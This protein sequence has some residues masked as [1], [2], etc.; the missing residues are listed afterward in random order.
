MTHDTNDPWQA[1]PTGEALRR[2]RHSVTPRWEAWTVTTTDEG[3]IWCA[4]RLV[5]M[6]RP[7]PGSA[8]SYLVGHPARMGGK[9]PHAERRP[10]VMVS[11][12][13]LGGPIHLGMDVA[14]DSIVVGILPQ[15]AE[16][17]VVERVFHDE[18]S[19]RRLVARLG[20]PGRLRACYEAGPTGYGLQR[21]LASMGV[22]CQVVAPALI[23]RR[24][25]DR[26]KTD[27][28]DAVRLARLARAGELTAIRVPT[29]AEEAVRDLCRARADLVD[30]R[31]RVRQRLKAFLL[32]HG[33]V[34]R[35]G[36]SWTVAHRQWLATQRFDHPALSVT[37]GQYRA[38]LAARDAELAALEAELMPWCRQMPFTEAVCRLACYRGIADLSALTLSCEVVDW[39]R[40]ATAEA[41]MG[42]TGLVPSEYSSGEATRRGHITKAGNKAVRTVLVE[43]AHAYR[44]RPAIG[45]TLARRQARAGADTLARSW[46]AQQRLCGRYRRMT[47][48][49]K[50]ASVTVTAVARELA[51]FAWAEMTA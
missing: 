23:P 34:Y 11:V 13:R 44:H 2:V 30:D 18:A 4:R 29:P 39:R 12:A 26:V 45:V 33:R 25:G 47:A 35:E 17:P 43:A 3:I 19:V 1:L 46:A 49:H 32:R 51:G 14:M 38:V 27:R 7:A 31:R 42:F 41:F 16:S 40:F 48:R 15:D 9:V 24:A 22:A 8:R 36:R 21:L 28:R 6:E 20:E 37:Y 5:S 50:P 10:A